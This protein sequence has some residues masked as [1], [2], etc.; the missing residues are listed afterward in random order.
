MFA[1]S[2]L[3]QMNASEWGAYAL[4][5]HLHKSYFPWLGAARVVVTAV[6]ERGGDV[7]V[8]NAVVRVVYNGSTAVTRKQTRACGTRLENTGGLTF[9]TSAYSSRGPLV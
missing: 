9:D 1:G 8:E 3:Q 7:A 5:A 4:P 6:G 2:S